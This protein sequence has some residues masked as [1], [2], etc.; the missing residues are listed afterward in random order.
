MVPIIY[1]TTTT[2]EHTLR[3]EALC[4]ARERLHDQALR[5]DEQ[6]KLRFDQMIEEVP[7]FAVDLMR[8]W[9][10]KR[11]MG[12]CRDCGRGQTMEI[13]QARCGRC[14]KGCTSDYH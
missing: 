1:E 11:I 9:L 5:I 7:E 4:F 3:Y 6:T 8:M 12:T 14:G 2:P 13:L 10:K